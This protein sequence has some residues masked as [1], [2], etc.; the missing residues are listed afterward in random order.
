MA[1]RTA[2][3]TTTERRRVMSPPF[4]GSYGNLLR[5][6]RR[7][8][9]L[10]AIRPRRET[11]LPLREQSADEVDVGPDGGRDFRK[12]NLLF[13]SVRVANRAGPEEDRL[14][15]RRKERQIAGERDDLAGARFRAAE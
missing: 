3:K 13:R 8:A 6:L 5:K 11:G 1:A 14:A 9:K 2:Q 4:P 12:R 7:T 15:P 10:S